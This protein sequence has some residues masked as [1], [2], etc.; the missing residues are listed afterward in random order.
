M[1][2]IYYKN[3]S[4]VFRDILYEIASAICDIQKQTPIIENHAEFTQTHSTKDYQ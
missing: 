1:S 3:T 2:K 4:D